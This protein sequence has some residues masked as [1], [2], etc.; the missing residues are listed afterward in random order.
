MIWN[1]DK[2]KNEYYRINGGKPHLD[3]NNNKQISAKNIIIVFAKES[4]AND[5][6]PGGHLLYDL[7][8]QGEALIFQNGKVIKGFWQKQKENKQ[9]R[10]YDQNNQEIKMVRGKIWIEILPLGNKVNY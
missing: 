10:F 2:N 4:P 6:Y 7:I 3:K 8:G 1:Y 9:M 5:G